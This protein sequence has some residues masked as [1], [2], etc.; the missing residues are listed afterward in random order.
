LAGRIGSS[1]L[2]APA[3]HEVPLVLSHAKVEGGKIEALRDETIRYHYGA[4]GLLGA[5]RFENTDTVTIDILYSKVDGPQIIGGAVAGGALGMAGAEV[6][7]GKGTASAVNDVKITI[8]TV[9]VNADIRSAEP[10][11]A[12]PGKPS[13]AGGLVGH[14]RNAQLLKIRNVATAGE[15]RSSLNLGGLLGYGENNGTLNSTFTNEPKQSMVINAVIGTKII[16]TRSTNMYFGLLMGDASGILTS[17]T[18]FAYD[19]FVNIKFSSFVYPMGGAH[20]N[21][22]TANR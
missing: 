6:H 2:K 11:G 19:P 21:S 17:A 16:P 7:T 22:P 18:P 12:L 1:D 5:G 20:S 15:V 4:G 10:D 8:D 14:V 13:A 9:W 3:N